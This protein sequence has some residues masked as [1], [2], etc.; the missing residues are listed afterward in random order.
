[1]ILALKTFIWWNLLEKREP[2]REAFLYEKAIKTDICAVRF[3]LTALK[4]EI[5]SSTD[6]AFYKNAQIFTT[7]RLALT[8]FLE[9]IC[10]K[11]IAERFALLKSIN[12]N[13]KTVFILNTVR[14]A[15]LT[16][17][18]EK[19]RILGKKNGTPRA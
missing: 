18:A 2:Y 15:L 13:A 19:R 16:F 6:R 14:F 11:I 12:Q 3:A 1:V 17:L 10:F 5:F 7:A 9:L 4:N 8:L